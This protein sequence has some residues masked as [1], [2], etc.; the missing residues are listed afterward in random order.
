M[1]LNIIY[2]LLP[3]L[4]YSLQ[5]AILTKYS[6]SE[7]SMQVAF[8]GQFWIMLVWLP[9]FYYF[10]LDFNILCGN[11]FYILLT[12]ILWS[13][14]LYLKFKSLDYVWVA[15]DSVFLTI[16]RISLTILTG[17]LL[18]SD[19]INLYQGIWIIALFIWVFALLLKEKFNKTWII[20]SIL[21]WIF[22]VANWYYFT[23]YSK[24]FNPIMA[25]Y[26]L[27]FFNW[28]FLV[29]LL[30]W[31]SIKE[32]KSLKKSFKIKLKTFW[33]ILASSPLVLIWSWAI[34][35]SYEIYSFTIVGIMLTMTIP[36]S[37]IFWYL[38]LHEKLS[39]KS[40]ISIVTITLGIILIKFFNN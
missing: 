21:W 11:I 32:K 38:L 6:R 29:F 31:K 27:E 15:V 23:I 7:W 26:I 34:S 1:D 28:V 14:Y 24:N 16:A 30:I 35:K 4:F 9:L 36:A 12:W 17:I 10:P 13:I 18:L 39:K 37:M 40:I 20:L 33:V 22:L 5:L 25:G 3:S 8:Y 2:L 19:S